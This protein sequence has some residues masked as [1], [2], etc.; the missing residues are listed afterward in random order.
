MSLAC[1]LPP[2]RGRH[3]LIAGLGNELT[4]RV[5]AT[6]NSALL[7][8]LASPEVAF[9]RPALDSSLLGR[10][11]AALRTWL[12]TSELELNLEVIEREME[13]DSTQPHTRSL[14]RVY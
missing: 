6:L 10:A 8:G 1:W 13:P 7:D 2:F 4:L 5:V 11:S 12:G 3:V 9:R 14:A